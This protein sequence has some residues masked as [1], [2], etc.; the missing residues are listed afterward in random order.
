MSS[1]SVSSSRKMVSKRPIKLRISNATAGNI[2]N[3]V[4][5]AKPSQESGNAYDAKLIEMINSAI[6]DTSPSV[7][8]EDVGKEFK[9]LMHF[10][11][12]YFSNCLVIFNCKTLAIFMFTSYKKL[13]LSCLRF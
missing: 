5:V 8:W 2:T 7:K 9:F 4:R 3:E 10:L 12:L 6:V 13:S 11:I 1:P